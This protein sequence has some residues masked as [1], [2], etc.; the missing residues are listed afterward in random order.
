[1]RNFLEIRFWF[2]SLRH[3]NY[4]YCPNVP[5]VPI[6]PSFPYK[7]TCEVQTTNNVGDVL[8]GETGGNIRLPRVTAPPAKHILE[9]Y[10]TKRLGLSNSVEASRLD[11]GINVFKA[12]CI[13]YWKQIYSSCISEMTFRL[14]AHLFDT[15]LWLFLESVTEILEG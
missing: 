2:N 12:T 10:T 1:M 3:L 15:K 9:D 8:S 4:S 13:W 11:W 7:Y 5:C 14:V 6:L